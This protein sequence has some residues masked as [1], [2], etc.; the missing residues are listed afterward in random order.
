MKS[1]T[2]RAIVNKRLSNIGKEILALFLPW[3]LGV[4]IFLRYVQ[5]IAKD[6]DFTFFHPTYIAALIIALVFFVLLVF[7][8]ICW[9]N[10]C[11]L[12]CRVNIEGNIAKVKR[13]FRKMKS[14]CL[15]DLERIALIPMSRFAKY[16]SYLNPEKNNYLIQFKTGAQVKLSGDMEGLDDFIQAL[17]AVSSVPVPVPVPV[18]DKLY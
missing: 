10:S 3:C 2:S 12:A 9:V 8:L 17:S 7:V 14:Y 15:G 6:G 5:A 18:Q 1:E 4:G 13:H 11:K 16:T